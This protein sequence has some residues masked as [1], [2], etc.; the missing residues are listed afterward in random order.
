M[1][2]VNK[3][4]DDRSK[5]HASVNL[6]IRMTVK[7]KEDLMAYAKKHGVNASALVKALI[8]KEIGE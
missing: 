6:D 3:L 2:V 7:M 1:K 4:V 8:T 5:S